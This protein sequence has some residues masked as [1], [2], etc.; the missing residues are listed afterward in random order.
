MS[1]AIIFVFTSAV[2]A[3]CEIVS[4]IREITKDLKVWFYRWFKLKSTFWLNFLFDAF[5]VYF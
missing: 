1:K 3:R 4:K 2:V 5:N